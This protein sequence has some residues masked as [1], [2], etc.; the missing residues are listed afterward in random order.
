ML[1]CLFQNFITGGKRNALYSLAFNLK[2]EANFEPYLWSNYK[3][4]PKSNN[5]NQHGWR[6][7]GPSLDDSKLTI[8]CLGGSTTWEDTVSSPEKS[9]PSVLEKL[10]REDGISANVINGGCSYFTSAELVGTLNFRGIY[11]NPD[12]IIIHTG[13]NDVGP[14]AGPRPYLPDYS[15]Y[16]NV[17]GGLRKN[18]NTLWRVAWKSNLWSVR[19]IGA[20]VLDVDNFEKA[21]LATQHFGPKDHLLNTEPL[22]EAN[23]KGL[24]NNIKSLIAISRINDATPVLVNFKSIDEKVVRFLPNQSEEQLNYAKA[25]VKSA[26]AINNTAMM[27][28]AS[29]N[30]VDIIPFHQFSPSDD[31]YFVDNCHLNDEGTYEKAK[32]IYAHLQDFG[33][34]KTAH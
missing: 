1:R 31:S 25:R 27:E 16:R 3:P 5:V 13:G 21:T 29:D 34:I 8:L 12:I 10:L 17:N 9:Y 14:F 11:T 30:N 20:F 26:L 23:T 18:D 33:L 22:D 32:F 28:I 24:K 19:L 6:Y 4:N 15:H 2:Y 7:R